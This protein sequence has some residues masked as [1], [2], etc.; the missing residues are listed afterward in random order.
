MNIPPQVWGPFFWNVIHIVALGYPTEPTYTHKKAVKEFFESLQVIV[1]C[2]KCRRHFADHLIKY[3][4]TPHLDARTDLFKW[5]VVL[6]NAVNKALGKPEFTEKET[7]NYFKRLGQRAKSP[8]VNNKVFE[9]IDYRSFLRGL[10]IG[11][12]AT[13]SLVGIY[14]LVSY[15]TE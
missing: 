11:V 7:I 10:L 2:P 3:P 9:E 12:A 14:L 4:I 6:H 13:A 5:T 15:V 8:I 1:P